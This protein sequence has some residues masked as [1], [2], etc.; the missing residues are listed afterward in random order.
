M[1]EHFVLDW[2]ASLQSTIAKLAEENFA[3]LSHRWPLLRN[4]EATGYAWSEGWMLLV[5]EDRTVG[6]IPSASGSP[7]LRPCP[8]PHPEPPTSDNVAE[9]HSVILTELGLRPQD[10]MLLIPI[11]E[12]TESLEADF[13][14]MGDQGRSLWVLQMNMTM[15]R[16]WYWLKGLNVDGGFYLPNGYRHLAEPC[17]EFLEDH[18]DYGRNVLLM[19]RFGTDQYLERLDSQLRHVLRDKGMHPVR[20]DDRVY[21]S[22][23][24]L[25]DNVCVYML[26][27]SMGIAILEDRGV[28]E[29]NP[30]VAIEYG[31]MRALDKPALLLA[32]VG[33]R[34]L[35]A[36]VIGT[37]REHFDL[38]DMPATLPPAV[39]R[40]IRDM[41]VA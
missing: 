15:S 7:V 40:W 1:R 34:N 37:L 6:S 5:S 13:E 12:D 26:C 8:I 17:A 29:F 38:L 28:D 33:F 30:N 27:C 41:G 25:W 39:D 18:P 32:D 3:E 11:V 10:A 9:L 31:F 2:A 19:T 4:F 22:N 14:H 24:N 20:A 35:R 21:P 23:R 36:D 16:H